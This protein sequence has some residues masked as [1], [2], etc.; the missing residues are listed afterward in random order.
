MYIYQ[1]DDFNKIE[2]KN[3]HFLCKSN[4]NTHTKHQKNHMYIQENT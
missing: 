2:Q 4:I 3:L 1:H